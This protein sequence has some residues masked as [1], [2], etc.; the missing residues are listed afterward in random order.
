MINEVKINLILVFKLSFRLLAER[1][2][3]AL[4]HCSSH[5]S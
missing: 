5:P 4:Q 1:S 3:M 2:I